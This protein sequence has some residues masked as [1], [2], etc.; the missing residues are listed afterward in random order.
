MRPASGGISWAPLF[1]LFSGMA[2]ST[3][4]SVQVGGTAK[5]ALGSLEAF[6]RYGQPNNQAHPSVWIGCSDC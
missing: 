3:R 4:I 2:D 6:T 1:G 5:R